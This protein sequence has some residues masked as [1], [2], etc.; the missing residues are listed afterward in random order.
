MYAVGWLTCV[1]LS[2]WHNDGDV[3]PELFAALGVGVGAILAAFRVD[4]I[5][6][7]PP[8]PPPP[9]RPTDPQ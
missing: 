5:G 1:I 2:A 7:K 6:A 8:P 3:P 9:P 4:E